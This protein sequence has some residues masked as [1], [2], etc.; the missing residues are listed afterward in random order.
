MKFTLIFRLI[1]KICL[2]LFLGLNTTALSAQELFKVTPGLALNFGT[3]Y[4]GNSG[5][6]IRISEDGIRT[7]TGTVI[8]F[9]T[10]EAYSPLTFEM[11]S[12]N[13]DLTTAFDIPDVALTGSNGGSMSFHLDITTP[14]TRF[15]R[16]GGVLTVGSTATNP[17]GIYSGSFVINFSYQ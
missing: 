7:T 12:P 15:V 11:Q 17:P 4:S 13:M 16:F 14:L 8:A 1:P 10:G 3:F 5:G 6:T 2:L 9:N